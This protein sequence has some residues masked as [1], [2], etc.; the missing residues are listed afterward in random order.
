MVPPG[1]PAVAGPV[2]VA[3]SPSAQAGLAGEGALVGDPRPGASSSDAFAERGVA[4][5]FSLARHGRFQVDGA[6]VS[7][8]GPVSAI[9]PARLPELHG[10]ALLRQLGVQPAAAVEAFLAGRSLAVRAVLDAH[11]HPE[12]VNRWWRSL[13]PAKRELLAA[14]AP[15]LVGN[16]DGVPFGYRDPANR[17]FLADSIRALEEQLASGVG[18]AEGAL[19]EQ[20]VA[21]LSKVQA[22]LGDGRSVP[23]RLLLSLD[24]TDEPKVAI[25]IGDPQS[26]DYVSFLVPGMFFGAGTLMGEWTDTAARLYEEQVSWLRLL[27]EHAQDGDESTVATVAWIGYQTPHLLNVGSLDL[28]YEGRDALAAIVGGLQAAR[29]AHEPYVSILAHSY[30]STAALMALTDGDFW[31][32]GLALIGSPGS[33]AQS[34]DEL[35]VRAGNVFV[36]EAA[37]DPIPNSAYFGS[38]PGAEAYGAKRMSV[39]GGIDVI[40]NEILAASTGHNEYFGAG[41]ESLRNLALIG[42]D[43]EQLVTDGT[44]TDQ[45]RTLAYTG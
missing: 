20:R 33:A 40:T 41:T 11:P 43:Q 6:P 14:K 31:V 29:T 4:Q 24:L 17:T 16:L 23:Q 44:S 13:A 25:S 5:N 15:E 19:L 7:L 26:A 28:A 39:A 1:Q 42:I 3:E 34:V 21:S 32:D 37:W 22:A 36:G 9:D 10:M 12:A 45:L 27:G 18:R 2:A 30:G 35:H 8:V 38:D